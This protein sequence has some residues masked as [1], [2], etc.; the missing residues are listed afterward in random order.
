MIKIEMEV[1][2]CENKEE[3]I[4]QVIEVLKRKDYTEN[5]ITFTNTN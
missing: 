4:Q 1:V 3:A 5:A 2:G